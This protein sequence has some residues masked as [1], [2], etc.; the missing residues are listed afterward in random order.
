MREAPNHWLEQKRTRGPINANCGMFQDGKF[1]IR[2][3]DG[4]GWD[5]VSISRP[6]RCPTWEEMDRIKRRIFRDE[7]VVMQLHVTGDNKVNVHPYCL[8]LWRPQN[9]DEIRT[10]REQWESAG[11]LW[12]YG[13]LVPAGVVPLPPVSSV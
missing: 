2:V 8:H 10:I 13:E 9:A 12:P 3:S 7:E 5:H 11:E 1:A 6:D 4:G